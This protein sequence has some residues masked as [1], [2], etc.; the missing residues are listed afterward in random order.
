M[1]VSVGGKVEYV[2]WYPSSW[3]RYGLKKGVQVTNNV[4]PFDG[5]RTLSW[6]EF[7]PDIQLEGFEPATDGSTSWTFPLGALLFHQYVNALSAKPA[8]AFGTGVGLSEPGTPLTS[9]T[10]DMDVM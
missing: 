7:S 3:P 1:C 6:G 9:G 10:V 8:D 4:Q 5:N 2:F